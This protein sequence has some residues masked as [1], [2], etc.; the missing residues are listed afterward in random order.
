MGCGCGDAK[1][2]P[3]APVDVECIYPNGCD[4]LPWG[5][6]DGGGVYENVNACTAALFIETWPARLKLVTEDSEEDNG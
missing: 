6:R 3:G 2:A 4:F 1:T 5:H